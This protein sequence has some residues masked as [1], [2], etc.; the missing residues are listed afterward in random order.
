VLVPHIWPFMRSHTL[1]ITLPDARRAELIHSAQ[2]FSYGGNVDPS[3][4]GRSD[5]R[6][7][8]RGALG[9]EAI[10]SDWEQRI[11]KVIAVTQVPSMRAPRMLIVEL[12]GVAGRSTP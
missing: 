10:A 2:Y 6:I 9:A 3:R 1:G 5:S 11:A 7:A 4:G 12:V 8:E